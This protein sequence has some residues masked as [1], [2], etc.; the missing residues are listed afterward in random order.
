MNSTTLFETLILGIPL[1]LT[2]GFSLLNSVSFFRLFKQK[3]EPILLHISIIFV[4]AGIIFLF[5]LLA[6]LL[7]E[8]PTINFFLLANVLVWIIFL[9]VG[10]A[11]FSAFL[12]CTNTYER[13]TL[14]IFGGSISLTVFTVINPDIY[15]LIDP[16]RI[17]IFLYLASFISV[18][19]L[20]IMAYKRVNHILDNFEG[21]EIRL[22][23]LTRRIFSLGALI[24]VYTFISVL[25]WLILKG[26]EQLDLLI[27]TWNVLDWLVYLN[28]IFYLAILLGAFMYSKKI[29]YSQ[30]DLPSL[31]NI[32]DS[33]KT[34]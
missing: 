13:Y 25:C 30:I 32:L 17:E 4:S 22:M 20:L 34:E 15:L 2:A 8:V 5:F 10:N 6:I 27:T 29:D 33:P 14:P 7:P 31:L 16:V 9:E 11:Y 18:I 24:L 1:L 3:E 12:N 28:V 26:I 23:L 19:Y 21:E